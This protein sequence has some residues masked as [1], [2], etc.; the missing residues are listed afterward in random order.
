MTGNELTPLELAGRLALALGLA[1]FLGLTFE[2]VYKRE[3]RSI[4]GGVRTFPMLALAGAMLYLI[5]PRQALAFNVGLIALA[6]WLH[7][8]LQHAS[9]GPSSLM[10]PASNLVAYLLG[11]LVG[12]TRG[13]RAPGATALGNEG[14][15]TILGDWRAAWVGHVPTR[16]EQKRL[17]DCAPIWLSFVRSMDRP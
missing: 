7:A 3:E 6:I 16:Y 9:A 17:G 13:G 15:G 4:P 1:V 8:F 14:R 2:E 11:P 5:E 12:P 10:V